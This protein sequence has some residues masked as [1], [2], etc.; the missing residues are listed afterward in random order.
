MRKTLLLIALA[1]VLSGCV[2][3]NGS[4]LKS[5]V[6]AQVATAVSET[7]P[8]TSTMRKTLYSY[9]LPTSVG[10]REVSQSST[11]LFSNNYNVLM[12]LDIVS[13]LSEKF[14]A[15]ESA[16][17]LRA[18]ALATDPLFTLTGTYKDLKAVENAYVITVNAIEKN[19]VLL[20]LQTKYFVFSAVIPM[21]ATGEVVYDMMKIV[22]T[23][24]INSDEVITLYSNRETFSYTKETLEIFSQLAPESGK[25]IDMIEETTPTTPEN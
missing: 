6:S 2:K 15:T 8:T 24:S 13:V 14:Y 16:D 11:V 10:R 19:V 22:R 7:L 12:N 23:C 25:I 1:L 9:Y 21:A 4:N 3:V 5:I 18:Y 20:T 17:P